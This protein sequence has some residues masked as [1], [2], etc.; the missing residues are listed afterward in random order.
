MIKYLIPVLLTTVFVSSCAVTTSRTIVEFD[1]SK[2]DY[3]TLAS[4]KTGESCSSAF[5]GIP[6]KT[7][8]SVATAAKNGGVSKIKH[9]DQH[10]SSGFMNI[11]QSLCTVVYGD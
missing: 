1:G 7:D 2:T 4:L 5:M 3:S 8:S 9:V 6:T 11:T 10:R